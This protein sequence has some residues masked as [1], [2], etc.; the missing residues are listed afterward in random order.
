MNG[1]FKGNISAIA[2]ASS[3]LLFGGVFLSGNCFPPAAAGTIGDHARNR[4]PLAAHVLTMTVTKLT[5]TNDGVCDADCSLREAVTVAASSDTIGFAVTGT[6]G[7]T[8]GEIVVA[9]NLTIQGPGASLLSVARSSGTFRIFNIS[10]GFT[11]MINGLTITGGRVT[12][13]CGG[14]ISNNGSTLT[15]TNS[16][17]S[18]NSAAAINRCGGGIVNFSPGVL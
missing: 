8:L 2:V 5:D 6:I 17:I 9:K 11:V 12:D 18:G 3:A 10:G 1:R 14:G 16:I 7:L 15:I 4:D 13:A